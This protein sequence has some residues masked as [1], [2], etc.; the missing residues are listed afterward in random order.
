MSGLC[1]SI[2]NAAEIESFD[3][4][5]RDHLIQEIKD[6]LDLPDGG[7][8]VL[9][10]SPYSASPTC[11]SYNQNSCG[12]KKATAAFLKDDIKASLND[13]PVTIT[14]QNA[15]MVYS[16]VSSK[17][18]EMID[19]SKS[20]IE[21]NAITARNAGSFNKEET[22]LSRSGQLSQR[23]PATS[24]IKESAQVSTGRMVEPTNAASGIKIVKGTITA[25]APAILVQAQL[26]HTPTS[27]GI[28]AEDASHDDEDIAP[29]DG[30]NDHPRS[31]AEA[32][33][34]ERR[35]ASKR[36]KIKVSG[37]LYSSIGLYTNGEWRVNE[38][39]P[40]LNER[41]WRILS[42]KALNNRL[43]TYD[44]AL[45]SRMKFVVDASVGVA[46]ATHINV[47]IDPW[48]YTGKTK[49]MVYQEGAD[50]SIKFQYLTVGSNGYTVPRIIRT[51]RYGD[52]V[53]LPET[54]VFNGNEIPSMRVN[55]L[56]GGYFILPDRKLN[57]TFMP[58]REAWLDF[59]PTDS[60]FFRVFPLAY[61]DQAL[62]SD[63]PLKLSNHRSYW[64]ESPWLRSWQPGQINQAFPDFAWYTKGYWDRSLSFST[65]DS[66]GQHLTA[67]RGAKLAFTPEPDT[68]LDFVI[69]SPKTLW[70]DYTYYDTVAASARLKHYFD[71]G[72]YVGATAV[73]HQGF[74]KS[75]QDAH[76][77]VGGLDSGIM[78]LENVKI[79]TEYSFSTSQY[80][81]SEAKWQTKKHG[82]AYY[83]SI[84]ATSDP[85]NMIKKDY[86]GIASASK[87]NDFY[88]TKLYYGRMD[89]NFESTLSNY[90]ATRKDAFWNH[91]LTFYPSIYRY[92][93]GVAQL[94]YTGE[95]DLDPFA[96][97]DGLDYGRQSY[98]WRGDVGL[99]NGDLKG[100]FDIRQ[101]GNV[102]SKYRKKIETVAQTHWDLKVND[103]LRTKFLLIRDQMPPTTAGIDPHVY[104][105]ETGEALKNAA[106]M[107]GKDPSTTTASLGARY[108]VTDWAALNGVWEYT[109]DS[110]LAT[111]NFPQA[112]LNSAFYTF[113]R[114]STRPYTTL[115]PFVYSGGLFDQPP[116]NYFNI[117]KTGLELTPTDKW[118]VYLDYTRNSNVFAGNI[119]D[120][121]NHFG[122]ESTY[123][124]TKN[125][126]IFARYCYT[127]WNDFYRLS[128]SV[129]DMK[130]TGYHNFYFSTRWVFAP[131]S[132][133]GLEYG[134]G[135][136][137]N[138][139]TNVLDPRLAYYATTVLNTQHIIRLTVLKKF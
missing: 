114:D 132:F 47:T 34:K 78:P 32:L 100:L 91:H 94:A 117:F 87:D 5:K 23:R 36:N 83:T 10:Q 29:A 72:L 130:Y 21:P 106:V 51:I 75:T 96:I 37:E 25:Q 105:G 104:D 58:V 12:D 50:D 84:I 127:R 13:V 95:D 67:L 112:D 70:Q 46:V 38:A 20:A 125:W 97:G 129:P 103:Q 108:Q 126:G 52:A 131:D 121:M 19:P 59:R 43:D 98:G 31:L 41:N 22:P 57:Y 45:Y 1:P 49:P 80:D 82:N 138:V 73:D 123:L 68:S 60:I 30:L 11:S 118:H 102:Q 89:S 53:A 54:K 6:L 2:S 39:N 99:L 26:A 136:A 24:T 124:I 61:E 55:T 4:I 90:H 14:A 42:D 69:A 8:V 66:T 7:G 88:K 122:I 133:L 92:L 85:V 137:Y 139:A 115:V 63:D 116:Y 3:K 135:P 120:N 33:A 71:E 128:Q 93:P 111:D 86:Y 35:R 119:D 56:T 40:D 74:L 28:A 107:G 15:G 17:G 109:N 62:T 134:V 48:S 113:Y 101:V 76:N 64:E 9:A 81:E 44:P 110:T 18:R 16:G 65:R 27:L 77:Y 79:E